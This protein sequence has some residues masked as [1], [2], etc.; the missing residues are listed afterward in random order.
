MCFGLCIVPAGQAAEPA[1]AA[2]SAAGNGAPAENPAQL[3]RRLESVETMI[4]KSSVAKQIETS[5]N[6][7]AQ[8]R[9][10][11]ARELRRQAAQAYAA[12]DYGKSNRLLDEAA[13]ALFEGVRLAAPPEQ[14]M[15][16]KKRRDFESRLESVKVLLA[17][18]KR[19]GSEKHLDV[20]EGEIS[21]KIEA[22]I[23]QANALAAANKLDEARAALD[24]AYVVNKTA[25]SGL[26][27]GDTLVR[28]LHFATKE[29]EYRYEIDRND[30][31]KMLIQVLLAE[32]RGT[33]GIDAMVQKF[34]E[35]AAQLRA[36]AEQLAAKGD[37]EGGVKM[38]E[39][40]TSELVRAIRSAGIYIPG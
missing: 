12:Q 16:Q 8:A 22:L 6:P 34:L 2:T 13:K 25:I 4:E 5:A 35:Q 15:Q 39:N 37:Y 31:H 21:R 10:E 9:R 7:D 26:R 33:P 36:T 11:Q 30:T 27:S 20:K 24:Q 3:A 14:V 23:Q 32:K 1:A 28:S 29:E 19:I 40:S 38:L 18:Q 17:A